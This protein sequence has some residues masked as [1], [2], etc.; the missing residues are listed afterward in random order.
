MHRLGRVKKG[1]HLVFRMPAA[2]RLFLTGE[3][4]SYRAHGGKIA[5]TE[6]RIIG[7]RGKPSAEHGRYSAPSPLGG[8]I[9]LRWSRTRSILFSPVYRFGSI[10]GIFGNFGKAGSINTH[11]WALPA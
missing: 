7:K 1:H 6:A 11:G 9:N 2:L 5:L 10:G 4:N 3:E 8:I